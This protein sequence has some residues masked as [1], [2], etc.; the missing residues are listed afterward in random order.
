MRKIIKDFE[1]LDT[2]KGSYP[3]T[4][5]L[6]TLKGKRVRTVRRSGEYGQN[7]YTA[8]VV[9]IMSN[10]GIDC[11]IG[12]DAPRGGVRGTYVEL[13]PTSLR[14]YAINKLLESKFKKNSYVQKND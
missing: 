6:Q 5:A 10:M 13:G 3:Y 2:P 9:E 14:R 7:D 8:Q 11:V 12:N 1:K 4:M